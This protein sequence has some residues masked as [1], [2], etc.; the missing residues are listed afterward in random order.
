M[1]RRSLMRRRHGNCCPKQIVHPVK[2]NVINCCSEE[3]VNHIHPSH[4]TIVNHHLIKN[5]HIFPHSTSVQNQVNSVDVYGGSFNTPS[6]NQVGGAN[7]GPN[8]HNM[9]NQN[10]GS[11]QQKPCK[12]HGMGPGMVGGMNNCKKPNKWC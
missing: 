12:P 8:T 3:T 2:Q 10:G 5:K 11:M 1:E 4:T 9:N 6:N 7:Q